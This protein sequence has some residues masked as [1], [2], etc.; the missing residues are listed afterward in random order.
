MGNEKEV[1]LS[2]LPQGWEDKWDLRRAQHRDWTLKI[3][4]R[5][6]GPASLRC[7][8]RSGKSNCMSTRSFPPLMVSVTPISLEFGAKLA[9]VMVDP[10]TDTKNGRG[11]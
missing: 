8:R 7:E 3:E 2:P 1:C 5:C 11:T 10:F 6:G 4:N 9:V